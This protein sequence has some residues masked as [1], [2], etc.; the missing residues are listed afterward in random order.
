MLEVYN[1]TPMP[2]QPKYTQTEATLAID[3]DSTQ[4][5]IL[6]EIWFETFDTFEKKK[7]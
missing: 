7:Q 1:Y 4:P 6:R 2:D 3:V 5:I